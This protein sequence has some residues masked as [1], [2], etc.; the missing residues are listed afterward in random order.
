[1][2]SYDKQDPKGKDTGTERVRRGGSYFQDTTKA[3]RMIRFS[4]K[5]N[6]KYRNIGFRIA[7]R[8]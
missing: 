3:T 2:K 5:P 6:S 4:D 7:C 1:M 8:S